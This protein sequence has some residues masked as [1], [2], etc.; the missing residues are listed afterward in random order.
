VAT[1]G[2]HAQKREE[3]MKSARSAVIAAAVN[4]ML[5]AGLGAAVH[6]GE[7]PKRVSVESLVQPIDNPWVANNVRFQKEVAAALGIDPN[8]VS[9]SGNDDS[10]VAAMRTMIAASP[11]G[12]LFDPIGEAA[13]KQDARLLE[14]NKIVGVT[15][16]RLVVPHIQDYKGNFMQAQVTQDNVEWGYR[17][18]QNLAQAGATRILLFMPPHGILTLEQ[19]WTGAKKYVAEHPEIKVVE[20]SWEG[21]QNRETAVHVMQRFLVK[22]TP[23]QDFDGILAIGSTAALGARYVLEQAK[24]ADKVKIVTADDDP[25]VMKALKS[26]ALVTTLGAHWMNGGFGLIVLYDILHG[27]KPLN[28]QPQFHLIQINSRTANAYADRFLWGKES[29]L[30]AEEIR[31]LSLTYDPKANLPDFMENLWRRWSTAGRGF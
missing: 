29:P 11:D 17:T 1:L 30:T 4:A 22:Y 16:D 18:M 27:H 25:D 21:P 5:V 26:D 13:A 31:S 24:V 7:T 10:N 8:T 12:I 20:E 9:D 15:E 2:V 3:Q 23:G 28:A 14:E 19:L 6:A